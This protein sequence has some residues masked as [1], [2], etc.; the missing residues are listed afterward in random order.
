M[1]L[2]ALLF[3]QLVGCVDPESWVKAGQRVF[4]KSKQ[5]LS[6]VTKESDS[7]EEA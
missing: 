3:P 1:H 6:M 7:G 5:K 4:K 2:M